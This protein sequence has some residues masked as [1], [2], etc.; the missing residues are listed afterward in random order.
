MNE[1]QVFN[2]EQ[3]GQIRTIIKDGEPWFVAADVCRALEL[4]QV[5][6]SIRRLDE[7]EKALNTI[8]GISRGNDQVSIINEPGLYSLV[9]TSRKPEAKAFKR[10]VAHDVIPSIRKHGMYATPATIDNILA[11]PDFGIRLLTEL[12]AERDKTAAL[13][14]EVTNKTQQIAEMEPKVDYYNDVLNSTGLMSTTDIAKV[15]GLSARKLNMILSKHDVQFYQNKTWILYQP[16]ANMGYAQSKTFIIDT[17]GGKL[18]RTCTYWTQTGR[19]FI[20]DLLAEDGIH[21][22]VT[23]ERNRTNKPD[24]VVALPV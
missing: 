14:K 20:H 16:Y 18:A 1:I 7:D 24:N 2:S 22:V 6:N 12:K 11:D 10:W 8:K 17:Q 9:L 13:T 23:W 19:K 15:Y 21:P 3:F 4:G 5:T